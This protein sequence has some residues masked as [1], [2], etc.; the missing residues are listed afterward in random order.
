MLVVVAGLIG[1]ADIFSDVFFRPLQGARLINNIPVN[2]CQ[3]FER[4]QSFTF[5]IIF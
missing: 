2:L 3:V 5:R 4:R 1:S